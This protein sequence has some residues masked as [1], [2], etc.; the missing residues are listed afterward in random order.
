MNFTLRHM[1]VSC[2]AYS[3]FS[4]CLQQLQQLEAGRR[5]TVERLANDFSQSLLYERIEQLELW[6]VTST[7][8][9]ASTATSD[10]DGPGESLKCETEPAHPQGT[11]GHVELLEGQVDM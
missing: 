5:F 6:K 10:P 3:H 8:F 9:P 2:D 7:P 4:R 1:D 11:G